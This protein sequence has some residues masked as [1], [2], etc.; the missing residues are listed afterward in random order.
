MIDIPFEIT[1][2]DRKRQYYNWKNI[3][4]SPRSHFSD[5]I[6]LKKWRKHRVDKN[7]SSKAKRTK[8]ANLRHVLFGVPLILA[9]IIW[10]WFPIL[11]EHVIVHGFGYTPT[12]Q[13]THWLW[14]ATVGFFYLWY[15]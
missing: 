12:L 15:T 14:H 8:S 13:S 7:H 1:D 2:Y 4:V 9:Y 11:T 10:R 3:L 5:K 6:V